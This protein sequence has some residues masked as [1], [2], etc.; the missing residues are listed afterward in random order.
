LQA[1]FGHASVDTT[2]IYITA[3]IDRRIEAMEA[4]M[5]QSSFKS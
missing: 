2:S 5:N 3:E 1:N 4:F